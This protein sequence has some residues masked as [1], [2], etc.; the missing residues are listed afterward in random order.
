MRKVRA[1]TLIAAA[2]TALAAVPALAHHGWDWTSPDPFV[3][4]GTIT[5]IYIGNPHAT[6]AVQ[7]EGGVWHID[8]APPMRTVAAGFVEGVASVG[9][10]VTLFGHRSIIPA[11]LS[12]KAVR[13]VVNG[14]TYDVYDDRLAPFR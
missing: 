9:D 2:A 5:E 12:M 7:A 14:R 10:A 8:L 13:V 11:D 1:F 3:L 6:L 4:E